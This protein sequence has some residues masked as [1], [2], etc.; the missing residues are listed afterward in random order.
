MSGYTYQSATNA[1]RAEVDRLVHLASQFPD[2]GSWVRQLDGVEPR[3]LAM[4]VASLTGTNESRGDPRRTREATL[5]VIQ[6]RLASRTIEAMEKLDRASSRLVKVGLL[7]AAVQ[8]LGAGCGV[9][10]FWARG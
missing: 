3:V 9:I 6:E 4:V 5:A 8:A 2:G 1:E 7:L 10:E